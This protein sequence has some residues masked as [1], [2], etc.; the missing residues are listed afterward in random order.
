MMKVIVGMV[1]VGN[2]QSLFRV[3]LESHQEKDIT[4]TCRNEK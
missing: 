1:V 2:T 3:C 4:Q